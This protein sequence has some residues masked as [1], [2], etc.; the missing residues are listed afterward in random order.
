MIEYKIET[1]TPVEAV[2]AGNVS[3]IGVGGAGANLIDHIA[4]EGMEGVDLISMNCDVRGLTS[5][6]ASRKVQLGKNVTQGLGCGGDPDLGQESAVASLADIREALTGGRMVFLCTGLGGGTGSGAAPVIARLARE[7]GAFVIVFAT[8]PFVFE[9]KR[10]MMQAQTSLDELRQYANALVTFE[11]DKMGELV[12]SKKGV[13]E[14]FEVA[15]KMICQS[16]RAVTT[17]ATQPGL[18]RIGMDDL[19]TALK[20]ADSRCIFGFGQAKGE[21]R[22]TEALALAL[23]SPLLDRGQLLEK[24]RNVLVHICGGTSLTLFEIE[25]LMKELT[26]SVSPDAQI[27]FGAASDPRLGDQLSVTIISSVGKAKAALVDVKPEAS[28]VPAPAPAAVR[29]P[30]ATVP[31]MAFTQA[32]PVLIVQPRKAPGPAGELAEGQRTVTKATSYV[33][34]IKMTTTLDSAPLPVKLLKPAALAPFSPKAKTAEPFEPDLFATPAAGGAADSVEPVI[35]FAQELKA[36]AGLLMEKAPVPVEEFISS[37]VREEIVFEEGLAVVAEESVEI[38]EEQAFAA[39]K[40]EEEMEIIAEE[41]IQLEPEV[42]EIVAEGDQCIE[43][44]VAEPVAEEAAAAET[45]AEN[46][47]EP[48]AAHPAFVAQQR[49]AMKPMDLQPPAAKAPQTPSKKF[50]LREILHRQRQNRLSHLKPREPQVQPQPHQ[51]LTAQQQPAASQNPQP[52]HRPAQPSTTPAPQ[53]QIPDRTPNPDRIPPIR[54]IPATTPAEP[55]ARASQP[56]PF[57]GPMPPQRTYGQPAAQQQVT[58][59]ERLTLGTRGR[60]EKSEPTVEEGEDLDIPTF[61]RKNR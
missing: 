46:D 44:E 32:V 25:T 57:L 59:D 28:T 54:P 23:K 39:V 47:E 7:S 34:V 49:P 2:A 8:M 18:I 52:A 21:T 29:P 9:G 20:N 14:A 5:S 55:A 11:N 31:I 37:Y 45:R 19:I 33:P 43:E 1:N 40:A 58:F 4:L 15:N 13:N 48:P 50:D 60:F 17:V 56:S 16:V 36:A 24:A 35:D 27:L 38:I 51:R 3:I 12:L 6:M 26:K 53:R 41:E 30:V 61:L 10:R 22:A 42:E